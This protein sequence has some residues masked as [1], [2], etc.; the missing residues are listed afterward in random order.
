[1]TSA[2][3][4]YFSL[5]IR[6]AESAFDIGFIFFP[7]IG[8]IHQFMKIRNLKSSLGFSKFV[9]LILLIAYIVRVFFWIGKRFS[10]VL[11][12][13]SIFGIVT[14]LL[15]LH[16]SVKYT[17]KN[18]SEK[19]NDIFDLRNFWRW[20]FYSDYIFFI[21]FIS[22][23]IGTISNLVGYEN[24]VYVEILG[25]ISAI[26]ESLLGIPQILE[27]Y[28]SKDVKAL[29]YIMILCW[30]LGDSIKIFYYLKNSSPVQLVFCGCGQLI[31]DIVIIFQIFYYTKIN[32]KKNDI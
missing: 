20:Q 10:L 15:L 19:I 1:M 26:V 21:L 27:N 12:L 28:S 16:I 25:S 18:F 31:C 23:L 8:F 30:F 3:D 24:Q 14:Q 6:F 13:Q 17:E 22:S 32:I 4:N 7:S 9:S 2:N 11:F 29:S 5:F